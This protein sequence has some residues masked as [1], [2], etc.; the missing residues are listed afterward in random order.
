[1]ADPWGISG[2]KFTE[3]YI[4]LIV[5]PI[6]VALVWRKAQSALAS[7]DRTPRGPLTDFHVA[8]LA[9]GRKRVAQTAVAALLESAQIRTDSTGVLHRCVTAPPADPIS[10]AVFN[11]CNGVRMAQ[12]T[13]LVGH[14]IDPLV[15]DLRARGLVISEAA[16]GLRRLV[17]LLLALAVDVVGVARMVNGASLNRPIG[18]LTVLVVINTLVLIVLLTKLV[19]GRNRNTDEGSRALAH[20]RGQRLRMPQGAGSG[21]AFAGGAMAAVALG[22]IL[23]YPDDDVVQALNY[24]PPSSGGSDSGSSCGGGSSSSCGSSCGGGGCGG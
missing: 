13:R 6:L 3:L 9:G 23:A 16:T 19:G 22:G 1:M 5:A 7:G 14:A 2:P 20:L 17:V 24:T 21:L 4:A 18:N 8:Y 15:R 10:R 11:R 12:A